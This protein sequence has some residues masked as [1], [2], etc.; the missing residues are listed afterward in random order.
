MCCCAGENQKKE[1]TDEDCV[2]DAAEKKCV[3]DVCDN[4][5]EKTV[6]EEG[7][8][9]CGAVWEKTRMREKRLDQQLGQRFLIGAG[10]RFSL[11]WGLFWGAVV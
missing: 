9:V 2:V 10:I 7:G 8:R 4:V 3:E 6:G 11:Y 1:A 5:W